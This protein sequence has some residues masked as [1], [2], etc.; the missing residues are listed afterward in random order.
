MQVLLSDVVIHAIDA[1]FQCC[2]KSFNRVCGDA[3][4]IFIPDVLFGAV[5]HLIVLAASQCASEHRARVRHDVSIFR[6]HLL[7]HRLQV[8]RCHTFDVPRLHATAALQDRN[9]GALS[10][11]GAR[12]S[13]GLSP[14]FT[15]SGCR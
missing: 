7:N 9:A 13:F 1:A 8:F 12:R 5:I 6:D 15:A 10:A 4:A 14:G 3:H 11:N 2:E